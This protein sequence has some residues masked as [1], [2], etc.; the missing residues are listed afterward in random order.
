MTISLTNLIADIEAKIAA[1]NS[2]TSTDELLK[3]IKA[4]RAANTIANTYDSS[5][6][7]PVDSA[8]VGNI[9]MSAS[10]NS[11][12][13]LDSASGSWSSIAGSGGGGGSSWT[14]MQGSVSGYVLGGDDDANP[15]ISNVI[16]KYSFS[17]GENASDVGDLTVARRALAAAGSSESG[18]GIAGYAYPVSNYS[19]I[20]DKF[21][22]ATDGNATDVGDLSDGNVIRPGGISS[23]TFGYRVGGTP[24][25]SGRG[26][27][28]DKFPF[29]SDGNATDV[30]NLT[31]EL[32]GMSTAA[33]TVEGYG[34]VF[35]GYSPVGSYHSRIERI[36]FVSDGNSTDWSTV[37]S[38]STGHFG[39]GNT[40]QSGGNGYL[41]GGRS[42][43]LR[44]MISKF[45]FS[46]SG[47][48]SDV[49]DLTSGRWKVTTNSSLDY[50][51]VVGG[52]DFSS[53]STEIQR[54]PFAS[55]AN[56]TDTTYDLVGNHQLG[57]GTQI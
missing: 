21:P 3:I 51:Y 44:N 17:T 32:N 26:N 52:N 37:Y 2:S 4:A 25:V 42:G 41:S 45:P 43:G 50:G 11:L 35:S 29:S 8:N 55:D 31:A 56:S 33:S 34:Y 38:G 39:G 7:M 28:I 27:T 20:I 5:G 46:S 9:L 54:F 48:S 23:N 13:V 22:F 40:D 6:V 18:Y 10:D 14:S 1:A 57:A 30:G 12:Y 36:S 47:G 53:Q 19:N 16:Q 24:D 15:T 49:G